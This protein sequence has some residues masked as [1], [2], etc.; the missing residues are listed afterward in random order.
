MDKASGLKSVLSP[1]AMEVLKGFSIYER[2]LLTVDT[3]FV[4]DRNNLI[5][6]LRKRKVKISI[7]TEITGI[8]R[9]TI[10]RIGYV[11]KDYSAC[12][13]ELRNVKR[14]LSNVQKQLKKIEGMFPNRNRKK[15]IRHN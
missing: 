8:P 1:V 11:P 2:R 12:V 13:I 9:S 7:L 5:R 6:K 15:R 10:S 4:D 14:M 3:P